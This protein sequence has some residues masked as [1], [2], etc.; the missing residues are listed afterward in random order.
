M[1][2]IK[3]YGNAKFFGNTIFSTSGG[4]GDFSVISVPLSE[5]LLSE[6]ASI[7][8]ITRGT[9]ECCGVSYIGV[10]ERRS[11]GEVMPSEL[12]SVLEQVA[13][14]DSSVELAFEYNLFGYLSPS[15]GEPESLRDFLFLP[16]C[17]V[18]ESLS[19]RVDSVADQVA[20]VI[21][22]ST[23]RSIFSESVPFAPSV[24]GRVHISV[25][26]DGKYLVASVYDHG[27]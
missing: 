24:D 19:T 26:P 27:A 10:F 13:K 25:T 23:V 6:V 2:N 21:G 20:E 12:L 16:L 22:C 14:K 1:A 3:I 5:G 7:Y 4:G 8:G 18:R 9:W 11:L 17:E 15:L